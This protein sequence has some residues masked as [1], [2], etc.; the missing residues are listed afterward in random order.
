M[1]DWAGRAFSASS[2][3]FD[4]IEPLTYIIHTVKISVNVLIGRMLRGIPAG[5]P[6]GWG[7]PGAQAAWLL[8]VLLLL[9]ACGDAAGSGRAGTPPKAL[10]LGYFANLTHAP[11]LVGVDSGAFQGAIGAA[12]TLE[13]VLFNAGP[14]AMQALLAPD[15]LDATFIGPNPALTAYLRSEGAAVRVV[16]GAASGGASLVVRPSIGGPGDLK[17]KTISTPQLGNT[18]D[19][20]LRVWLEEQGFETTKEGGGEVAVRP[21]ENAQILTSFATGQIDGAWVPEPWATR[22]VTEAGGKVLVD[23]RDLWPEGRFA[24]TLL[25]VRTDFLEAHPATVEALV[26]AHVETIDR[27]NA[28]PAAAQKATNAAIANL[29]GKPL[30]EDLVA[31]AWPK[32]TFTWDPLAATVVKM[33]EHARDVDLL[34]PGDAPIRELYDLRALDRTLRAAGKPAVGAP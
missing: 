29:T 24:T 10:R 30:P 17:G 13:P 32:L 23:E 4:R 18:Q 2:A 25:L 16:A 20:A 12:T 19:V 8:A 27:L 26:K 11:A 21:Q 31:G 15:S 9:S 14:T 1:G 6:R 33:A 3:G 7:R 5:R 28:D 34:V 22:L